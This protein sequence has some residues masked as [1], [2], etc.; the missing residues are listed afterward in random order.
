MLALTYTV[1]PT[2]HPR[3]FPACLLC[4]HLKS[5]AVTYLVLPGLGV[6]FGE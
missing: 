1:S 5:L 3:G 4:E 6:G 2:C